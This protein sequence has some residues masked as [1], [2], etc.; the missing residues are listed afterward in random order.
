VVPVP[1]G[2][3]GGLVW[4]EVGGHGGGV[5]LAGGRSGWLV[6]GEVAG[7]RGGEVAGGATGLN[8]RRRRSA[9]LVAQWQSL[10]AKAI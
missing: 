4:P 8:R 1:G 2:R 10:R 6:H 3:G 5:N 7:S 9:R